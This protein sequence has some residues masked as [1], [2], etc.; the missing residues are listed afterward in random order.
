MKKDQPA[1]LEKY[2][3]LSSQSVELPSIVGHDS[4]GASLMLS[5]PSVIRA[6]SAWFT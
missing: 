1:L 5:R 6:H 2:M 3:A 4:G